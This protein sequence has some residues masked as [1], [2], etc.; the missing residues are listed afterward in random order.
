MDFWSPPK[1]FILPPKFIFFS[2]KKLFPPPK[3][4]FANTLDSMIADINRIRFVKFNNDNWKL[5]TC[6][7]GVFLKD[8]KCVHILAVAV[9]T[10]KHVLDPK[11]YQIPLGQKRKRGRPP[12]MLPALECS[13]C[14]K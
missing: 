12:N 1:N 4:L 9:R 11:A 2:T 3:N 13:S 5:S 7:C 14:S 10:K 6:S 8:Y